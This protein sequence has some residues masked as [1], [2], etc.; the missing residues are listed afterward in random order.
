MLLMW[1]SSG[2]LDRSA[3]RA[4]GVASGLEARESGEGKAFE[5]R[6]D[7]SF[8]TTTLTPT[9]VMPAV[10]AHQVPPPSEHVAKAQAVATLLPSNIPE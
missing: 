1:E 4:T 9:R 8:P 7:F 5:P 10:I 3:E 2:T 6:A